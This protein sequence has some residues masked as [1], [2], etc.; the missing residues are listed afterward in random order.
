[1]TDLPAALVEWTQPRPNVWACALGTVRWVGHL[2]GY[3]AIPARPD[4]LTRPQAFATV[5]EAKGAVEAFA[6]GTGFST[7]KGA[8]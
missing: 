7:P 8:R 5:R 2:G 3:A 6:R 1:M 4:P